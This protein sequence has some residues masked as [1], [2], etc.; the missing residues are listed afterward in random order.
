M[1]EIPES[2]TC[3]RQLNESI[4]GKRIKDVI[5]NQNPHGFAWFF[6]DPQEYAQILG[7]KQIGESAGLGIIVEIEAEEYRIVLGD[8]VN[9]RYYENLNKLPAKHQ[10]CLIFE[11][12]SA[13][14]CTVQMY[15]GMFV[16][17]AG[18]NQNPYYLVAFEKPFPLT[19]EFDFAYFMQLREEAKA[20]LSAKAFLATEQRIPGIGNGVLQDI[21]LNAGVHPKRKIQTLRQA[22]YKR[23][24]DSL[25][26]T[27]EKMISGGGRDTEKDL[28]GNPGGYATLLSWKTYKNPC[29][30]CG[31]MIHKAAYLGGSVYFCESCQPL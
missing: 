29:P 26:D 2:F 1:L 13:L 15:G 5:A 12:D 4:K 24:Y 3:A 8:G 25:C 11:D 22:D 21:L 20:N 14:V 16:F 9:I 30:Y 7:G 31:G 17:R 28:Y 18:E 6:G 23:L 10:L 19:E 27:L